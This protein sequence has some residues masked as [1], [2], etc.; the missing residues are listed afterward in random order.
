MLHQ[1]WTNDHSVPTSVVHYMTSIQ[2]R[3]S[4]IKKLANDN[5]QKNKVKYKSCYD[6]KAKERTFRAG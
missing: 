3:L 4:Q 5:E 2:D 1:K 6:R